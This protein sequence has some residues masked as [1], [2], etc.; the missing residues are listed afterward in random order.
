MSWSTKAGIPVV[1]DGPPSGAA[2]AGYLVYDNTNNDLY[3]SEGGG[4]WAGF[5]IDVWH[6]ISVIGS[7]TITMSGAAATEYSYNFPYIAS[8]TVTASGSATAAIDTKHFEYTGSGSVTASGGANT[9]ENENHYVY[10]P[11]GH[12]INAYGNAYT[13]KEDNP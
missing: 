7:G 2:V 6:I 1:Q 9:V 5:S 10:A 12:I 11:T 4:D 8:G 3:I 13:V